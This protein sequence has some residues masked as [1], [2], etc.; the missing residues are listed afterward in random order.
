MGYGVQDVANAYREHQERLD[1][2]VVEG[3]AEYSSIFH[4][5]PDMVKLYEEATEVFN[6]SKEKDSVGERVCG[7]W[8]GGGMEAELA[9]LQSTL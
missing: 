8:G 9:P 3:F 7:Y 4:T 5:L 2:C 6:A 1:Q